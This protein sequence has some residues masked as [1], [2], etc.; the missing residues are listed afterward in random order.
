MPKHLRNR[1]LILVGLTVLALLAALPSFTANPPKW[2]Q[3]IKF[4]DGPAWMKWVT[5]R[6]NPTLRSLPMS[7][8]ETDRRHAIALFRYG[9]IAELVHLPPG[10]KGLYER[11]REKAA[12]DYTIPGSTRTRVAPETLRDWLKRYR[13]GGFDALL[14]KARAD[15]SR[16]LPRY[17]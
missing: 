3:K 10:A 11:I 1:L 8:P 6:A 14:P 9:L 15:R 16:S 13:K 17:W 7:D 2:M 5:S 12:A 4:S